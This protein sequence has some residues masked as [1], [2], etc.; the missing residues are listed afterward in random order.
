M[1]EKQMNKRK[2]LVERFSKREQELAAKI[3]N[4]IAE[5][6]DCRETRAKL[7]MAIAFY[8]DV[9]EVKSQEISNLTFKIG[10]MKRCK[11]NL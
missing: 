11:Y 3:S 8:A 7:R 4:D 9:V 6:I 1:E 2:G 5:N 10:A